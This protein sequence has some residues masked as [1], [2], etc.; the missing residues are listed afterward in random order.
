MYRIRQIFAIAGAMLT[1]VYG[2]LAYYFNIEGVLFKIVD[3]YC[4]K[5]TPVR[6]SE[7]AIVSI[8]IGVAALYFGLTMGKPVG[9]QR[10]SGLQER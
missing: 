7:L 9:L 10:G 6:L 4:P 1:I 3:P 2:S 8:A 5:C